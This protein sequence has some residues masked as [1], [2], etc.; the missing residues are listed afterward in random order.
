MAHAR[1]EVR[2]QGLTRSG[3]LRVHAW[4]D[5]LGQVRQG[6]HYGCHRAIEASARR[7]NAPGIGRSRRLTRRTGAIHEWAETLYRLDKTR[8]QKWSEQECHT[9]QAAIQDAVTAA[10]D[11]LV[12][13]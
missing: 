7:T 10:D 6:G 4:K 12:A 13:S 9:I 1:P 2:V 11:C 8:T 5:R 3:I